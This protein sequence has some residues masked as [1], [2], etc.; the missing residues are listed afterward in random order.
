MVKQFAILV[1]SASVLFTGRQALAQNQAGPS[2]EQQAMIQQMQQSFQMIMQNMQAKGMDPQ[3]LF[4]EM[5]NGADPAD[6][7]QELI[8]KGILDQAT[9]MQMQANVQKFAYSQIRTQL[10]ITSDDEWAAL[11]PMIQK[12]LESIGAVDRTSPLAGVIISKSA[13]AADLAK[14]T[15]DLRA[16]I[17]DP[18][19]SGDQFATLL[20]AYR[21]ARDAARAELNQ[22]RS[23]LTSVLTVRQEGVLTTLGVLE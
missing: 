18:N 16:A 22:A 11:E 15:R 10:N 14:A 9:F 23:E 3:Q 21:D 6:I 2:P 8:D 4:Q 13:S 19:T 1:I 5:Q 12:V 7:Q 20:K 17:K